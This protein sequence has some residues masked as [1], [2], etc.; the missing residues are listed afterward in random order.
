[1]RVRPDLRGVGAPS[2]GLYSLVHHELHMN[3][4]DYQIWVAYDTRA[5]VFVVTHDEVP[6]VS[7]YRRR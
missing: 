4:V 6:I 1:G 7:I 5:P 2:Q 3:E